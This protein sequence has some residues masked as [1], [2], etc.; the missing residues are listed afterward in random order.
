MQVVSPALGYHVD[1]STQS[2]SKLSLSAGSHYLKFL[3]HVQRVK[4]EHQTGGIVICGQSVRN[5]A[6]G[7]VSLTSNGN[8]LSWDC[9]GFSKKLSAGSIGGRN[10]GN[11]K[12]EIEETPAIERQSAYFI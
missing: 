10:A 11:Q 1:V 4:S 2:T 5:E 3:N 12:S 8:A 9:R 6:V 7:E